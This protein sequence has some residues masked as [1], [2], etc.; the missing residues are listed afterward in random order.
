MKLK[1]A[2]PI[3]IFLLVSSSCSKSEEFEFKLYTEYIDNSDNCKTIKVT[4]DG[5]QKFS[6]Q[7]CYKGFIPNVEST[8]FSVFSGKHIL[9]AE[10]DG[11]S[12]ILEQRI[13]FD[14]SKKYGYLTYN[15]INSEF[16]FFL[17]SSGGIMK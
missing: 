17:S 2:L 5:E 14:P 7:I 12:V 10:M 6:N 8:S 15:N 13:E 4:I 11:A 16:N 1:L 3:F 9:R